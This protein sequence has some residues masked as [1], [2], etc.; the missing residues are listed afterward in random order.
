MDFINRNRVTR[1]AWSKCGSPNAGTGAANS[2]PAALTMPLC[3]FIGCQQFCRR[4]EEAVL[5]QFVIGA[6]L[7]GKMN[8]ADN[9]TK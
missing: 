9:G 8:L 3:V 7:Y 2:C 1:A 6:N 5:W 4:I